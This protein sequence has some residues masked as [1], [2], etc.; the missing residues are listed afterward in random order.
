MAGKRDVGQ[1]HRFKTNIYSANFL[2]A[3]EGL[4]VPWDSVLEA[5]PVAPRSCN[6]NRPPGTPQRRLY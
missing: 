6:V 2:N 5:G 3:V 4:V 1:G